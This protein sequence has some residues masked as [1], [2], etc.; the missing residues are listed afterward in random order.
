[1]VVNNAV[2]TV[3]LD[4]AAAFVTIV[5]FVIPLTTLTNILIEMRWH[6]QIFST[7]SQ[8]SEYNY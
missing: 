8:L 5:E 4:T 2:S 7:M 3:T 6:V 1:M